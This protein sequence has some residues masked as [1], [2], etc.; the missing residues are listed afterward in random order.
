MNNEGE[1]MKIKLLLEYDGS[2]FCGWQY[3]DNGRSVQQVVE[4]GLRCIL[5]EEVRLHGAGRTDAGVHARGMVA[6]FSTSRALPMAAYREGLNRYLPPDV[7]VREAAPVADDFHARFAARGKWY[8]YSLAPGRVRTPL[9]RKGSWLVRPEL[10]LALMRRAARS[11]VGRHDFARFRTSGC[12][13]TTTVRE[14]YAV[15]IVQEGDLVLVDVRG[16]AFLRNMV[17]IMVGTL[18]EIGRGKRPETDVAALLAGR[19]G[20]RAGATAP[21]QGLCLMA[22]YYPD[23]T[24]G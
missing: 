12:D 20:L 2:D 18:V 7:A 8:R 13:A 16:S 22:V 5:G 9:H 6:H 17:R 19:E 3:Q 4:E 21:P 15:E 14:V 10:D 1:T 24:A 11:F 23:E